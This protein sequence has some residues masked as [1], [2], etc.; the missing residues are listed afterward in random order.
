[1]GAAILNYPTYTSTSISVL[2]RLIKFSI[3]MEIKCTILLT[4]HA[5]PTNAMMLIKYRYSTDL[6][7]LAS[8]YTAQIYACCIPWGV[9]TLY[10][11][12]TPWGLILRLIKIELVT[13]TLYKPSETD[14]ILMQIAI[15]NKSWCHSLLLGK[16]RCVVGQHTWYSTQTDIKGIWLIGLIKR[17]SGYLKSS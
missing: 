9:K 11:Y 15:I 14:T 16:R 2:A 1:M 12:H 10:S 3:K 13:R 17:T 7:A 6:T 8:I 5:Q 4:F